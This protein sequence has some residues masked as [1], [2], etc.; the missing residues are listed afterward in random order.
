MLCWVIAFFGHAVPGEEIT[1]IHIGDTHYD[2]SAAEHEE[3]RAA[4]QRAIE[5]MNAIPGTLYPEQVG[6]V[7]G[8]PMGVFIVGDL[9]EAKESDF[10]AFAED[11]GLAGGEA[12]LDFPVYEGA[13]NHDGRPST[14]PNGHARRAIIERNPK[15]P[16]LASISENGLHYALDY[17]GVH[18]VQ[19][20]EYAGMD[21]DERY[22]GNPE[23]KRKGQSYGNP[24]EKSLQFLRRTL[25][26]NVGDS[27]RPVILF[28]HYS[29][30]GWSLH[31][32]GNYLAWWTEEHVLRLWETIQGYNV[33][34]LMAG[35][36]HSHRVS[37]WNGIPVYHM[38]AVRGFAVY[39]IQGDEM[40]RVVRNLED[41]TW[42]TVSRG[43]TTINSASPAELVQGPYL[44][45]DGDPSSMTVL[46]RTDREAEV[47]FR[48]GREQFQFEVG[49][50][51]VRPH[52]GE[53]FLY[54][55]VLDELEPNAHYTY[56]LQIG[57]AY[58]IGMFYS[59]P[60]PETDKVKFLVYGSTSSG[61][62]ELENVSRALYDHIYEDPAYHSI[63]LHSG[64]W[65]PDAEGIRDWD[66][67]FFSRKSF[68]RHA[69]HI[70]ARMPIVGAAGTEVGD[71]ALFRELFPYNLEAGMYYSF[72]YGPV[73]VTVMDP[74]SDY[75]EGSAQHAWLVND[76]TEA[77]APW[78]I[79][80]YTGIHS[81]S[82]DAEGGDE[83]RQVLLPLCEELGVDMVIDGRVG[84]YQRQK[85]GEIDYIRLGA[86]TDNEG[87]G[88]RRM[89][90][91][92]MKV[93][94]STMTL[95]IFDDTRRALDTVEL[96]RD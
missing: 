44:V 95:E 23:Y 17:K 51:E 14:H 64:N 59:A 72:Q 85:A 22:P 29:I 94:G 12:L 41:D 88:L 54:R 80:V 92:A 83:S 34:A 78:K 71:P 33:I 30:D 47:E 36:D 73:H 27:G 84:G 7:A 70:L 86:A 31:A 69:R 46:W 52:D 37:E 10:A 2:T 79:L 53:K 32:W 5:K 11:W 16:H 9:T 87:D 24:A 45:Y 8:T 13:G 93:E 66:E 6:G 56:Q 89:Y 40:V 42:G 20:N 39:R 81:W 90:Y 50:V 58:D 82:D 18:F 4:L 26:E 15:R 48:W 19:L 49:E 61:L 3:K 55:V 74:G 67:H 68:A 65:I 60:E 21:N 76:L 38:D 63:L 43:S 28:Q 75:S 25:E 1:F 62:A 96:W 77:A 57:D 91:G 35:H